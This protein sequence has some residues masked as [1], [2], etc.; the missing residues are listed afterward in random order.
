MSLKFLLVNSNSLNNVII[1]TFPDINNDGKITISKKYYSSLNNNQ[2]WLYT[3]E[4]DHN[5]ILSDIIIEQKI[6]DFFS[7]FI[8]NSTEVLEYNNKKKLVSIS[9]L[10]GQKINKSNNTFLLF[11]YD[12]GSVEKKILFK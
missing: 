1:D 4:D 12:D 6:W 9:N 3:H 7:L 11:L 8:N 10:F 2:V 5:W